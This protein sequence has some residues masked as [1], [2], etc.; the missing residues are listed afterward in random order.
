MSKSLTD[1]SVTNRGAFKKSRQ[2]GSR[3]LQS[4]YD[5]L[6]ARAKAMRMNISDLIRHFIKDGLVEFDAKHAQV[7]S[8]LQ[9]VQNTL[10]EL[11]L[12]SAANLV[13][14]SQLQSSR[15]PHTAVEEITSDL[16]RAMNDAHQ[17]VEALDA[18]LFEKK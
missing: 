8:S 3:L 16:R 9:D 18:G 1:P 2:V 10:A 7:L 14:T 13:A 4:E 12:T 6:E 11:R 15:R 5:A 17:I